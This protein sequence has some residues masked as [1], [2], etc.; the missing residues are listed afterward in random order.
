MI[1]HRPDHLE[2]CAGQAL[3][4]LGDAD[5]RELVEHLSSG[6]PL[7]EA[8]LTRLDSSVELL[9]ASA[10]PRRAP[11]A[12]RAR[13]LDAVRADMAAA[14]VTPRSDAPAPLPLRVRPRP[15]RAAWGWALAAAGFAVAG[16]L[17]WRTIGELDSRLATAQRERVTAEQRLAVEQEWAAL[18]AQP[19]VVKVQL[20]VTPDGTPGLVA[21]VTYDP[22]SHRALIVCDQ[23]IAP[24]G[25]DYELWSIGPGGP[26]SLGLVH[27]DA[28]GRAVI[29]IPELSNPEGLAAFAVSLE[30]AGGA[31]T[32]SAPAGPVVMV[33]KIG[34]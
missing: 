12:L 32:R 22:H 24:S 25:H 5:R 15:S 26:T 4:I 17:Q 28:Q 20:A 19:G 30:Q 10:P 7:C 13:V 2:L 18:P 23:L 1:P 21:S 33:G 9:A 8:E 14:G 31:P 3:A 34:A 16:V 29:R 6:C 11:E 27:A